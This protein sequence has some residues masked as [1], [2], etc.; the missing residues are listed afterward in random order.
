MIPDLAHRVSVF[1]LLKPVACRICFDV[2]LMKTSYIPMVSLSSEKTGI[3]P[4]PAEMEGRA[5]IPDYL[6]IRGA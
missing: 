6:W 5:S 1:G 4:R 3:P 2:T